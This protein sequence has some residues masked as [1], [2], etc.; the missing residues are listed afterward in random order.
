MTFTAIDFETAQ[1]HHVCAVGIVC[2]ENGVIVDEYHSLVK[3]PRNEYNWHCTK[4]H[5][6]TARH[7]AT[8]PDFASIYPEIKKRLSNKTV[9]AH[10]ASFDKNVLIKSM[11]DFSLNYE[12]LN[13]TDNWKC[14]LQ[15]YKK[16][17]YK[18]A[19]LSDCCAKH[20][21]PLLHHEA[22]SDARGCAKLYL[23]SGEE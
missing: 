10:N 16:K 4:V 11:A 6:I 7:T 2:V 5:G 23:L 12:E 1:M 9:V 18:P 15:I 22:L 14:T 21:I 20:N 13:I 3:P 8:A 19:K 17:G